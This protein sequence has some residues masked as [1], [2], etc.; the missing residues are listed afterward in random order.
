MDPGLR[1]IW[2]SRSAPI[3]STPPIWVKV[4]SATTS[5][6]IFKDTTYTVEIL[7]WCV[8]VM[9]TYDWN[10]GAITQMLVPKS[11]LANLALPPEAITIGPEL[12]RTGEVVVTLHD[13][14]FR[15]LEVSGGGKAF[16]VYTE[17]FDAPSSKGLRNPFVVKL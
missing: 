11:E 5:G 14:Y 13:T 7:R 2:Q 4:T 17:P 8:Q 3:S 12:P 10:V 1:Q 15:D 6:L 9:D 16:L